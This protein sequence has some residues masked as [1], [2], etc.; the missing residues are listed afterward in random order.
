[1]STILLPAGH[2][3]V[4]EE[5]DWGRERVPGRGLGGGRAAGFRTSE[6]GGTAYGFQSLLKIGFH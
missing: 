1:V 4:D 5:R 3:L 6:G 2:S